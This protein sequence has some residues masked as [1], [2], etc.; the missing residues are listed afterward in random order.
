PRTLKI[1]PKNLKPA[2]Y[3]AI[4]KNKNI[5]MIPPVS[6]FDMIQLEKNASLIITDSG[7]VQKEAYFYK[8]P[9][10]IVRSETEWVEIV[11]AKAARICDAD[12]NKIIQATS[13]FFEHPLK[14]LPPIFGNG[15]AAEFICKKMVEHISKTL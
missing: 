1:L 13:Y 11:K 9:C 5:G 14:K 2:L 7:G 12:E 8:K 4:C 10:I 3:K 15:K 6:F